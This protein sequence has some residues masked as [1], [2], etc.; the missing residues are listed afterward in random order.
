MEEKK[1]SRICPQCKKELF[2][3]KKGNRDYAE[4]RNKL[5]T[6]CVQIGKNVGEKNGFFGKKHSQ[7]TIDQIQEKTKKFRKERAQTE[8]FKKWFLEKISNK[9]SVYSIWVEKYGEEKAREL[10][11]EKNLKHSKRMSGSGNSMYSRPS[12]I[13]SGN[14]WS[15]WYKGWYFRSLLELSYMVNYIEKEKLNWESAESKEYQIKYL[16][17]EGKVRNYYPDFVI[18]GN[19]L[20]EIKPKRLWSSDKVKRKMEAGIEFAKNNGY[21]YIIIDP[22]RLSIDEVKDLFD[23]N[24][25]KFLPRYEKKYLEMYGK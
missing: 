25:I 13:G 5:C 3:T 21:E 16:D 4:R 17:F 1:Y 12:P 14:G 2:H 15:G 11:N 9:R 22:V 7:K 20:V 23:K 6:S 24:M 8:E 19:K 18:D 10:Q